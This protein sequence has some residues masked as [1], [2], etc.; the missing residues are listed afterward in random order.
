MKYARKNRF[1]FIILSF[2]CFSASTK[3]NFHLSAS[4]QS[5]FLFRRFARLRKFKLKLMK[6][7]SHSK[8]PQKSNTSLFTCTLRKFSCRKPLISHG[9]YFRNYVWAKFFRR[10]S[11]LRGSYC[12]KNFF[13]FYDIHKKCRNIEN[14]ARKLVEG[15]R[16]LRHAFT[17][18]VK[19]GVSRISSKFKL[20]RDQ[21]KIAES[22]NYGRGGGVVSEHGGGGG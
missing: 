17:C 18:V 19:V 15:C 1:L 6:S 14:R 11:Y 3:Y 10:G 21:R 4:F 7:K 12:T 22:A 16:A 13:E 5:S 2:N 9:K 20:Y 8:L